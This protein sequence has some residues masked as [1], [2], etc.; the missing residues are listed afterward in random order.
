MEF[1]QMQPP[2]QR[3]NRNVPN[4]VGARGFFYPRWWVLSALIMSLL[5]LLVFC[6][7]RFFPCSSA[8]YLCSFSSWHPVFQVAATWL[9]FLLLAGLAFLLGLGP[10]EMPRRHRSPLARVVRNIS[11]FGPLR[12]LL[13]FYGV[14]ALGVLIVMWLLDRATALSFAYLAI[15]VFV[16]N[17]SFFHQRSARDR[18][19]YLIGYGV[20]GLLAIIATAL[21]RLANPD[22]WPFFLAGALL[23]ISGIAAS[24]WRP[25]PTRLLTAQEQMNLN[26]GRAVT[27]GFLLRNIWPFSR[28]MPNRPDLGE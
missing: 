21:Y 23:M 3:I 10:L 26:I 17:T 4:V 22:I 24:F 18:R 5:F 11:E 19:V 25:R 15:V 27:P 7:G 9:V 12:L 1:M 16:G 8:G 14:I 20:V 13:Q 28:L 6:F 2:D